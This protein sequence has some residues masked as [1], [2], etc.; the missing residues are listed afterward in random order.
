MC[1]YLATPLVKTALKQPSS[2]V[3]FTEITSMY[4][5]PPYST[6]STSIHDKK[7][8]NPYEDGYRGNISQYNKTYS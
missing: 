7:K 1:E 8:K 4:G 2:C 5:I 6:R 3:V